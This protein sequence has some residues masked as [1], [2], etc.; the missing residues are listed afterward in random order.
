MEINPS[1]SF[2]QLITTGLGG[3]DPLLA[4]T[5]LAAAAVL[6]LTATYYHP[7]LTAE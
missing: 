6:V 5:I 4:H 3:A 7:A 2:A 1:A